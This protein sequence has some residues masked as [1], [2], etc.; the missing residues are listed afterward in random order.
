MGEGVF[1]LILEIKKLAAWLPRFTVLSQQHP[2]TQHTDQLF[3][4]TDL[5]FSTQEI[6]GGG[7]ERTTTTPYQ[8]NNQHSTQQK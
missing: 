6:A 7:G 1:F 2:T 5:W 8:N 3:K 4:E